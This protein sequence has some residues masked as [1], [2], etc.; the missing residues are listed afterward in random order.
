MTS[1]EAAASAFEYIAAGRNELGRR[2][3]QSEALIKE[4]GKRP[5]WSAYQVAAAEQ[6]DALLQFCGTYLGLAPPKSLMMARVALLRLAASDE[7]DHVLLNER[8]REKSGHGEKRDS[9]VSLRAS[10]AVIMELLMKGG[11]SRG[12]ASK[13]IAAAISRAGYHA[14]PRAVGGWRD[15]GR[16]R[17]PPIGDEFHR[18]LAGVRPC[19]WTDRN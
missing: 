8:M 3:Q 11:K 9:T 12:E 4:C 5:P 15:A 14:T 10:A 2:W 16:N 6:I 17:K 1:K 7:V 13:T 19:G 18:Q